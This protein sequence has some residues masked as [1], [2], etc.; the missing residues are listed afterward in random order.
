MFTGETALNANPQ[1]SQNI[2][3]KHRIKTN[4]TL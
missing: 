2:V 1:F 4:V 3:I